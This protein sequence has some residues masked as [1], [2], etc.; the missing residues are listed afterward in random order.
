M[1]FMG[2]FYLKNYMSNQQFI[3]LRFLM[4]LILLFNFRWLYFNSNQQQ[5]SILSR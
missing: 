1:D 5:E 2:I 4:K 3:L